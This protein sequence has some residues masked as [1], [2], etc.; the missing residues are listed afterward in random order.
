MFAYHGSG[1]SLGEALVLALPLVVVVVAIAVAVVARRRSNNRREP[2]NHD[3]DGLAQRRGGLVSGL[4]AVL[5]NIMIY[6]I[7]GGAAFAE[8]FKKSRQAGKAGRATV[9]SL[10]HGRDAK[11]AAVPGR[12]GCCRWDGL[13]VIGLRYCMVVGDVFGEFFGSG[14]QAGEAG[15]ARGQGGHGRDAK[16]AAVPGRGGFRW[17]ADGGDGVPWDD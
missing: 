4:V 1:N 5:R 11:G 2:M 6:D 10:C 16:G 8:A 3:G 17:D 13:V 15:S 14:M 9:Q 7:G 12:G